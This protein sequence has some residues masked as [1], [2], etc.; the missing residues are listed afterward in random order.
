MHLP[1]LPALNKPKIKDKRIFVL[2][3]VLVFLGTLYLYRSYLPILTYNVVRANDDKAG[4]RPLNIEVIDKDII[5]YN[6]SIK[7][8]E[9]SIKQM[10][11]KINRQFTKEFPFID[12]G[13]GIT[14]L[15]TIKEKKQV[16]E[17]TSC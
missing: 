6:F 14:L 8:Q 2:L 1:T 4:E 11:L 15:V 10:D 3:F 13:S 12:Y 7:A 9:N 17:R 16:A 5:A